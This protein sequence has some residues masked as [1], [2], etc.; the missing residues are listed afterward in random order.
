MALKKSGQMDLIDYAEAQ[1]QDVEAE[2]RSRIA[3]LEAF[4]QG[5]FENA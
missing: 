5:Y 3:E 4:A 2:L 1:H